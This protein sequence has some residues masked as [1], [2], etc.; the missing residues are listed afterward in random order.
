M[1]R[2]EGWHRLEL[3]RDEAGRVEGF[4]DGVS[5][6]SAEAVVGGQVR[7]SVSDMTAWFDD[8][9]LLSWPAQ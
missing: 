2:S 8:V 7:L 4:V 1:V 9:V 3:R 5:L 6:G